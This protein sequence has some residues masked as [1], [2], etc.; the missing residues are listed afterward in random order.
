[1][2]SF[3]NSVSSLFLSGIEALG[4]RFPFLSP[5]LIWILVPFI[6]QGNDQAVLAFCKVLACKPSTLLLKNLSRAVKRIHHK[7]GIQALWKQWY[8]SRDL[9]LIQLL[10]TNQVFPEPS[11]PWI[12]YTWILKGDF[13]RITQIQPHLL[14]TLIRA[15]E[16]GDPHIA[17]VARRG[18]A[19]LR[20]QATI[21][22]L[23]AYW[24]ESRTPLVEEILCASRYVPEPLQKG[25][26]LTCL[27]TN[28]L[29]EVMDCSPAQLD[30]LLHAC[31]DQDSEIRERA[32][33]VLPFLRNQE[34]I[35]SLFNAWV[36]K[37]PVFLEEWIKRGVFLPE[38][39]TFVW[40]TVALKRGNEIQTDD[41]PFHLVKALV[42][43]CFDQDHEIQTQARRL[44]QKLPQQ[45]LDHLGSLALEGNQQ[46]LE[47]W[48]DFGF[49]SSKPELQAC[50]LLFTDQL[51]EYLQ[52]DYEQRLMQFFYQTSSPDMRSRI[53]RQI[54]RLAHPSLVKIL[55]IH[56]IQ[57]EFSS[58][59]PEVIET[60]IR[61]YSEHQQWNELW[62]LVPQVPPTYGMFILS[63]LFKQQEWKPDTQDSLFQKLT[64]E[65]RELPEPEFS[66]IHEEFPPLLHQATVHVGGRVND[67][68]TIPNTHLIAIATSNRQILLWDF[69]QAQIKERIR[70]FEHSLARVVPLSQDA[71]VAVERSTGNTPCGIY[72]IIQNQVKKI[73][74]HPN[75]AVGIFPLDPGSFL[76][77]YK[78]SD[79][80]LGNI[81]YYPSQPFFRFPIAFS[82]RAA[83]INTDHSIVALIN[84]RYPFCV[85]LQSQ[86]ILSGVYNQ[87]RLL[88][89]ANGVANVL[90]FS[91]S[92]DALL[93]GRR[94]GAIQLY[95]KF[96]ISRY[97]GS[98]NAPIQFCEYLTE[99][100][101]FLTIAKDGSLLW[102][103][104]NYQVLK[105]NMEKLPYGEVTTAEVFNKGEF[106][107]IG[108][109]HRLITFWDLRSPLLWK[110]L[111][112]PL[113]TLTV[114]DLTVIRAFRKSPH[115]SPN[116]KWM[117]TFLDL[118]LTYRTQ[119]DIYVAE[120][121]SIQPGEFDIL[122]DEDIG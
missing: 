111:N 89:Q 96:S 100:G 47:L 11:S 40:L 43:L 44:L 36:K 3:I 27:K 68:A 120:P 63:L 55:A 46:A 8:G 26:I 17:E 113:S 80:Y 48:K 57:R 75:A 69:Q 99:Q 35:N 67:F 115:L 38:P 85:N 94:N 72:S 104:D 82:P 105:T 53:H 15:C 93:V 108:H 23:C 28:R 39:G 119:Y 30:E 122:L 31:T 4:L 25:Y 6:N 21:N 59:Q 66:R 98:L 95:P 32:L 49:V 58:L 77:V 78:N 64:H 73:G 101:K 74:E 71:L 54:Q 10:L 90:T 88:K 92:E 1:M 24:A 117:L 86:E 56:E 91:P 118:V 116:L 62:H 121:V 110:W 112:H 107:V 83:A 13:K 19:K 2:G 14:D 81:H 60:A 9:L 87:I 7:Q 52:F 41:F 79:L 33:S 106:L 70:G 51:E 29:T 42:A 109:E 65:L 16:D 22:A 103:D 12:V 34:T 37:R 61:I 97:I 5:F 50:L 20:S 18:L 45:H 84:N 102:F 76:L 114:E